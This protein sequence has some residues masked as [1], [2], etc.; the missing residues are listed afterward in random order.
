MFNFMYY[1]I[2][3]FVSELLEIKLNRENA[4]AHLYS[5]MKEFHEEVLFF[6]DNNA[7]VPFSVLV[8]NPELFLLS[9]FIIID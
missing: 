3:V 5:N 6:S 9:Q 1:F 8:F 2:K 4:K 7:V